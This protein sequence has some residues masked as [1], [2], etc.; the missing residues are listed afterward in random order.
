[1]FRFDELSYEEYKKLVM[2]KKCINKK[3]Q[4]PVVMNNVLNFL[5]DTERLS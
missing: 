4:N 1:V 3:S 5:F 2:V